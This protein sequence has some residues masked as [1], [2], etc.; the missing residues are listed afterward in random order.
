MTVHYYDWIKS[1]VECDN[2]KWVGLGAEMVSGES[3]GDGVD[4]HCKICDWRYGCIRY[5]MSHE[6]RD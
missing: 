1:T 5:P 4:K 2:C 3:F 6:L